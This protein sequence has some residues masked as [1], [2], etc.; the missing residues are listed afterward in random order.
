MSTT[1]LTSAVAAVEEA[2]VTQLDNASAT[3]VSMGPS[4]N[5]LMFHTTALTSFSAVGMAF[6]TLQPEH[7]TA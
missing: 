5:T 1:P 6:A 2:S 7:V 3:L 4:A